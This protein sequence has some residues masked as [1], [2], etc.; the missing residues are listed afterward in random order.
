MEKQK[1]RVWWNPQ[2]GTDCD[3]FYVPVKTI[4]EGKMIMDLLAAYD[5]FQLQNRIK[6]DYTNVGG[7][8]MWSEEDAEWEDWHMETDNDYFDNVDD[9][10][11]QCEKA[12][13]L[14]KFNEELFRQI[15]WDK[16]D[17]MT[18]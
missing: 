17:R 4:E 5:A 10:C 8:E 1:L 9:Y 7:L 6:P 2:V 18:R 16:I 14:G 3:I 13:E 11:G 15:D 12:N